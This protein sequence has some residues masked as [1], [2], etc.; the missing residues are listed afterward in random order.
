MNIFNLCKVIART[1][2][3]KTS[4][5][6]SHV[7]RNANQPVFYIFGR[8]LMISLHRIPPIAI[9]CYL[10]RSHSGSTLPGKGEGVNKESNKK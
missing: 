9:L 3:A 2:G 1:R 6:Y 5:K 10:Y 4:L 7:L 8:S